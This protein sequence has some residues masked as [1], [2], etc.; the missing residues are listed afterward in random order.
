MSK[1]PT[2]KWVE[3]ADTA[4]DWDILFSRLI[5]P[6]P[7][8]RERAA[9]AICDLLLAPTTSEPTF[10]RLCRW[11]EGVKLESIRTVVL[12]PVAKAVRRNRHAIPEAP[13]KLRGSIKRPSVLSEVI[14]ADSGEG[15]HRFR[16]H[17]GH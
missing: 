8:V 3:G 11:L 17:P 7:V 1:L 9:S 15:G 2:A 4:E 12:L 6:S 14:L 16:F 5:W 10:D 13:A